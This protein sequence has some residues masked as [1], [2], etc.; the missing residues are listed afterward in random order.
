MPQPCWSHARASGGQSKGGS[1][2]LAEPT[3]RRR[4]EVASRHE[5]MS[6]QQEKAGDSADLIN[7]MAMPGDLCAF[8]IQQISEYLYTELQRFVDWERL[9][10]TENC[11]VRLNL[12]TEL[13]ATSRFKTELLATSRFDGTSRFTKTNIVTSRFTMSRKIEEPTFYK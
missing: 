1:A 9:N 3:E 10:L 4:R 13:L 5:V 2:Q 6:R 12:T 7:L 8:R 11:W